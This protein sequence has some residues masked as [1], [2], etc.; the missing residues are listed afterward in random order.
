MKTLFN[1][2]AW[3]I[4]AVVLTQCAPVERD[5]ETLESVF[6]MRKNLTRADAYYLGDKN[7]IGTEVYNLRMMTEGIS[8]NYK[9]SSNAIALNAYKGNGYVLYFE[10]NTGEESDTFP[11]GEFTADKDESFDEGTFSNAYCIV[12]NGG[13]VAADAVKL[14]L[15]DG[16]INVSKS[17]DAYSV[18]MDVTTIEGSELTL[19]YSGKIG[20][21]D[22]VYIHEPLDAEN[23]EFDIEEFSFSS[24]N[25]DLDGNY[26]YDS[27]A[28]E[29]TLDCKEGRVV[30]VDLFDEEMYPIGEEPVRPAPGTY[31]LTDWTYEP[32][33]F[34]PGEIYKGKVDGS[35]AWLADGSGLFT[36]LFYL[37]EGTMV[38][39]ESGETYSITLNATSANGTT[40]K[41]EYTSKPSASEE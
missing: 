34:I 22:P 31:T 13:A 10:L 20:V 5:T 6:E 27:S 14:E 30:I 32:F 24:E 41:A 18:S 7:E 37:V 26:F 19:S 23:L 38:V 9:L 3:L 8:I 1:R 40:I 28:G 17:G 35:Y 16:K 36:D 33:T 11:V 15:V 29:L 21:G 12:L 25:I 4:A 2:I 39:K